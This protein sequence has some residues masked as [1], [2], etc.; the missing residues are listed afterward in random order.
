MFSNNLLMAA[1]GGGDAGYVIEGSGLFGDATGNYLSRAFSS[2]DNNTYTIELIFKRT[3]P[4]AIQFYFSAGGQGAGSTQNLYIDAADALI[5]EGYDGG[6]DIRLSTTQKFR[7]PNAWYHLILFYDDTPATPGSSDCGMILNGV[8]I[9]DFG[10][11]AYPSQNQGA[12]WNTAI[13]HYIGANATWPMGAPIARFT[14]IDGQKLDATSFGEFDSNGYWQLNDSS[15]LTFG[16]EGFLIEGGVDMAAGTDSSA[17]ADFIPQ[18][19]GTVIGDMTGGG[20]IAAGFNSETQQSE[21]TA[22]KSTGG[23]G[24]TGLLGKD[25]GSGVTKTIYAYTVVSTTTHGFV[26]DALTGTVTLTLQGST[27]NFS[28]SVVD[29]H[30]DNF[31]NSA[32]RIVKEYTSGITTSTAYRYHRVKIETATANTAIGEIMFW[33]TSVDIGNP[34]YPSGTITATNDS[35]TNDAE[36][37]IGNYCTLSPINKDSNI[38]LENGNLIADDPSASNWNTVTSTFFMPVNSGQW[39]FEMTAIDVPVDF[40]IG[41]G[42]KDIDLGSH[43]GSTADGWCVFANGNLKYNGGGSAYGNM[44]SYTYAAGTSI[45]VAIDMDQGAIWFSTINSGTQVWI[46]DD[47]TDSSATVLAEIEAGTTSSAAFTNITEPVCPVMGVA[48]SNGRGSLECLPSLY[49]GAAPDGYNPLSTANMPTPAIPDPTEHH[50]VELVNH[51]GSSTAFTCN[52]D[53][54]VY[55]TLF[56]IKNRDSIEKWYWV[57]GLNGYGKY[58]SS[59]QSAQAQQTDANVLGVSGTTITLGSTLAN[60]AYVVECHR[61]GAAGGVTNT[62][63]DNTTDTDTT[64]SVNSV[65]EFAIIKYTGTASAN[66]FGHGLSVAPDFWTIFRDDTGANHGTY[67]SVIGNT[68]ALRLDTTDITSTDTSWWNDTSPTASVFSLG[69]PNTTTNNSGDTYTMYAWAAVEGYSAFGSYEG[70]SDDDGPMITSNFKTETFIRKRT[71][72]A[73]NNWN[74]WYSTINDYNTDGMTMLAPNTTGLEDSNTGYDNLDVLSNGVKIHEVND[75]HNL[76]SN[77][78]IYSMWGGR[79][80]QG[81]KPASNTSQGRAR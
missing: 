50:Q 2:G 71:T 30:T 38:S 33:E 37:D 36:N 19:T 22:A 74:I 29:L 23:S 20:G 42:T 34:F 67:H 4:G 11:E 25:W 12:H 80:I 28:G 81:P 6:Y 70:N 41:V 16:A 60:D 1:A 10:T 49:N 15:G 56:I 52:W 7:D 24:D 13:T 3:T 64:V 47:G 73:S 79:P 43:P 40:S 14:N 63:G 27:D 62:D 51:D 66:T 17:A 35:P 69:A 18:A 8:Q 26:T 78:Y 9:T 76:A 58:H 55:D 54:D 48:Y 21:T 65:T 45:G 57:D 75:S 59:D 53:A 77:T 61:G 44:G 72:T 68:G 31:A 46:D 5:W 32:S 39:Y